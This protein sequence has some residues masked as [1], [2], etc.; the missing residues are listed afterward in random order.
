MI[1][2]SQKAITWSGFGVGFAIIVMVAA[3]GYHNELR[4]AESRD[5]L[6]HTHQVIQGL[7]LT[8]STLQDGE[9]GQR[10]Y[11]LTGQDRYLQPF[12]E[13]V[14]K[15]RHQINSLSK[16]TADNPNQQIRIVELQ[17]LIEKK[18]DELQET[19]SLRKEKGLEAALQVVLT[20]KGKVFMDNIREIMAQMKDEEQQL[21]RQREKKLQLEIY[22]R[23]LG[24]MLGGIVAVTFFVLSAFLAHKNIV[25]KQI[26]ELNKRMKE[27][28]D[29]VA[30]DLRTPLTRLRGRAELALQSGEDHEAFQEALSDCLEESER[31]IKMLNTFLDI[32]EAET[33][34][35][36][37]QADLI[38]ISRLVSDVLDLYKYVAEDK[39]I[40]IQFTCPQELYLT[41]DY[42]RIQQA[43]GN[44]I[45]NAIKYTP[46]DGTVDVNVQEK[47]QRIV[48]TIKDN[49]IGIQPE[50][51]PKIWDR[52]YRG[53]SSRSQRGLGLGLSFV[54]AIVLAHKGR[55]EV[56]SEPGHG[57]T[58]TVSLPQNM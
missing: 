57:S 9:T 47:D 55:I 23:R 5:W 50:E 42:A 32:S 15:A 31:V 51:I 45:D 25:R 8:L 1:R 2:L 11:I 26:E 30:H 44:L 6:I 37:L 7:Q 46:D 43:I 28:L 52:L 19:I 53:D 14:D 21:L 36:R 22:Y 38:D 33:G 10:G 4:D 40:S 34:V 49:G 18:F 41:A 54:R 58:F 39:N 27:S 16:L 3:A 17:S 13:A 24:M 56:F 35:M 48:I 12:Y 20:G 29:N